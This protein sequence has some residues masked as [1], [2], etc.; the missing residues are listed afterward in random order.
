[1]YSMILKEINGRDI[2][3]RFTNNSA[4]LVLG[5]TN[6]EKACNSSDHRAQNY[7]QKQYRLTLSAGNTIFIDTPDHI[8]MIDFRYFPPYFS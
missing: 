6:R 3:F 2:T 1:M 7:C 4:C 8:Y 5:L